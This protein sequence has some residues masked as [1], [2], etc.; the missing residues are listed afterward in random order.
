MA[1]DKNNTSTNT[2]NAEFHSGEDN[3]GGDIE[4]GR[5]I[6]SENSGSRL[7]SSSWAATAIT[8]GTSTPTT[9][10]ATRTWTLGG[11]QSASTTPQP[12]QQEAMLEQIDEDDDD[13]APRPFTD[14][15]RDSRLKIELEEISADEDDKPPLPL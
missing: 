12:P 10:T 13:A 4:R 1:D 6:I 8:G 3:D 14:F 11:F 2:A 5:I 15:E 7:S 9:S